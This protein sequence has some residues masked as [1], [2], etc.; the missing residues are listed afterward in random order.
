MNKSVCSAF[1]LTR[2]WISVVR[3][4]R[5]SHGCGG[6][7]LRVFFPFCGGA[8]KV[9]SS[10]PVFFL[11]MN[12]HWT[13]FFKIGINEKKSENRNEAIFRDK[14]WNERQSD[15]LS[16]MENKDKS[17]AW[18]S[19]GLSRIVDVKKH[20]IWQ[21]LLSPFSPHFM[22]AE[23]AGWTGGE[24]EEIQSTDL[25]WISISDP[26]RK[27]GQNEYYDKVYY[28]Y[29]HLVSLDAGR[30]RETVADGERRGTDCESQFP[31][32]GPCVAS[33]NVT[34]TGLDREWENNHLLSQYDIK[35]CCRGRL[36]RRT[37]LTA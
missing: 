2:W 37:M 9:L 30:D 19:L 13:K 3:K 10:F 25:S 23:T 12:Y 15:N 16:G 14:N 7:V 24:D 17:N 21:S 4:L 22:R 33:G 32:L 36:R 31:V 28:Y 18:L 26:T 6:L 27:M 8:V 34:V 5:S 20:V 1:T 29:A 11:A 35:T